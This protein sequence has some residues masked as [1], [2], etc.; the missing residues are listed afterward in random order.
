MSKT[1]KKPASGFSRFWLGLS[2]AKKI[3]YPAVAFV[4]L[5]AI[6]FGIVWSSID[7]S[8]RYDQEDLSAFI[9]ADGLTVDACRQLGIE[10]DSGVTKEN[11]YAQIATDLKKLS[12]EFRHRDDHRLAEGD[13]AGIYVEI[14]KI[15]TGKDPSLLVAH[16][17]FKSAATLFRIGEGKLS[18]TLEA[19]KGKVETTAAAYSGVFLG[20]AINSFGS[21]TPRAKDTAYEDGD[22][23]V[24]TISAKNAEGAVYLDK[25]TVILQTVK[26]DSDTLRYQ[27][28]SEFFASSGDK[29]DNDAIRTALLTALAG[30][31]VGESFAGCDVSIK[32]KSSDAEKQTVTFSGTL[33]AAFTA[34]YK[35]ITV[36]HTEVNS[37]YYTNSEGKETDLPLTENISIKARICVREAVCLTKETVSAMDGYTVPEG[38]EDTDEAYA[39]AARNAAF[40]KLRDE[41]IAKQKKDGTY[42]NQILA[43]LWEEIFEKYSTGDGNII[44]GYPEKDISILRSNRLKT[45]KYNY[46]NGRT[47]SG[48]DPQK[49]DFTYTY[50]FENY[51]SYKSY[52]LVEIYELDKDTVKK[53]SAS[54]I[55]ALFEESL[56]KDVKA[57]VAHKLITYSLAKASGITGY[58]DKEKTDWLNQY[59][60]DMAASYKSYYGE[61]SA[62]QLARQARNSLTESYIRDS[63]FLDKVGEKLVPAAEYSHITWKNPL[64]ASE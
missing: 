28:E 20:A 35:E 15:E 18:A 13:V 25:R 44:K 11:V 1:V 23:L 54:E 50:N 47:I 49:Q 5:A 32:M 4:L 52:A 3:L 22:S 12:Q 51:S 37:F 57:I 53:L 45:I 30:K 41:Y 6:V 40:I 33:D 38:T 29:N 64:E 59:E 26:D 62:A 56:K 27:F 8:Y 55:D 21:Y 19:G 63:I 34:S 48:Y 16:N 58:T 10:L 24:L 31:K 46:E 7:H 39:A 9:N 60:S 61:A 42:K 2:P 17:D 36:S 14:Y 43:A